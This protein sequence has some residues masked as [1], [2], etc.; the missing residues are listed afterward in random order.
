M[1]DMFIQILLVSFIT[2]KKRNKIHSVFIFSQLE[3]IDQTT[4]FSLFLLGNAK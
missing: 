2:K 4:N 1:L 3:K